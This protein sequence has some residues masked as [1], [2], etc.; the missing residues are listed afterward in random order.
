MFLQYC[1]KKPLELIPTKRK[2]IAVRSIYMNT[3][4]FFYCLIHCVQL[5]K[6]K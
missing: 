6:I 2:K 1:F 4:L 5:V 3:I